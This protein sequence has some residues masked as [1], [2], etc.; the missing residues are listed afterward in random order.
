MI[1]AVKVAQW[2]GNFSLRFQHVPRRLVVYSTTALRRR[3]LAECVDT[4]WISH[5]IDLARRA[6]ARLILLQETS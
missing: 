5:S 1:E 4:A 3:N 2:S 6:V